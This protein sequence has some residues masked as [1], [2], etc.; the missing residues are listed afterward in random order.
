[1]KIVIITQEDSF[2][3]PKNIK[4]ILELDFA[5]V[6]RIININSSQSLVNKKD[7]F[8]KGFGLLQSA[9]MGFSVVYNKIL[10]ILDSFT[11]Y[12]LPILSRSL[13]SVSLKNKIPTFSG[14]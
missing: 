6:V 10:D 8:I 4:K 9:K 12:K 7:L 11:G 1:M 2:A 3:V 5:E 14:L 13:K